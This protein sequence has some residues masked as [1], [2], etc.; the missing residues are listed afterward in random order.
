ME[1]AKQNNFIDESERSDPYLILKHD[2]VVGFLRNYLKEFR[3]FT[4]MIINGLHSVIFRIKQPKTSEEEELKAE[5]GTTSPK[6][7]SPTRKAETEEV[8][9]GQNG[10]NE[11]PTSPIQPMYDDAAYN[12]EDEEDDTLIQDPEEL[13]KRF[14]F[15]C[16]CIQLYNSGLQISKTLHQFFDPE[17]KGY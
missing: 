13:R 1:Y 14:L 7:L 10:N 16:F 15:R 17:K 9:F 6:S 8:D 4:D 12:R 5:P 11:E 3:P 2:D